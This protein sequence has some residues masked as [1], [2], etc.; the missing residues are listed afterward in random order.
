MTLTAT[1]FTVIQ[2]LH[3]L[4][5]INDINR[6]IIHTYFNFK[7][8]SLSWT[9]RASHSCPQ[10]RECTFS[11]CFFDLGSFLVESDTIERVVAVT[12]D[13][14]CEVGSFEFGTVSLQNLV[15][16]RA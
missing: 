7:V 16:L 5:F 3:S 10:S 14:N 11:R 1:L 8:G 12:V 9:S 4:L 15:K 6:Y 2:H 13:L